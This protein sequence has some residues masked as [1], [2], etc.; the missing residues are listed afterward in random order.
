MPWSG[1][2]SNERE[3]QCNQEI[4]SRLEVSPKTVMY[5]TMAIDRT[6]G[7]RRRT[8]AARDRKP[9]ADQALTVA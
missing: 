9:D 2:G 1:S 8:E 6:L 4:A 5:H 7:V 3:R